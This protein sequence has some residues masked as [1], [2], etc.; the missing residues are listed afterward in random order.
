MAVR[1]GVVGRGFMGSMHLDAYAS[2][3]GA[4]VVAVCDHD[5]KKLKAEAAV[6]GNIALGGGKTDWG[7]VSW[8]GN[9]EALLAD[10]AVAVVDITLPTYLHADAAVKAFAAGK[11]VICE[12]PMAVTSKDAKRMVDAAR[13]AGK[14]LFVGH[15]IRYWPAYA[16]ARE[17]VRSGQYGKVVSA[18]FVRLSLTPT[19]SWNNWL[20]D[21]KRSGGAALDLHIH[22]SDF[23][24]YTFGAPKSVVSHGTGLERGRIDHLVTSYEYGD[25][26]LVTAEGSWIY[27]PGFGFQMQFTI[28][29][30]KATLMCGPDLKLMLHPVKGKSLPVRVSRLDG[31]A[32]ELRDF[33]ACLSRDKASAVIS[34]ESALRSVQLLEAEM[35]SVKTGRR[36]AVRL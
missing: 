21:A 23:V 2:M 1:I 13:K 36:V 12:K 35:K 19:W 9:L 18:R 11:H 27:A 28:A 8:Y 6:G 7:K 17:M 24:L 16:K 10:E 4:E 5:N 20:L 33:V 3:R 25:G 22:D 31:Y 34:P 14:R 15:C 32:L 29:L 26:K 30:E